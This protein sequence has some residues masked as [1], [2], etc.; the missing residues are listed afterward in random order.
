MSND[1]ELRAM[2]SWDTIKD[3]QTPLT[4]GGIV[5]V[6]G[7]LWS[8]NILNLIWIHG[9]NDALASDVELEAKL[10]TVK[11]EYKDL[12]NGLKLDV[13]AFEA[14]MMSRFDADMIARA[15]REISKID[16]S[17][18]YDKTLTEDE[19]MFKRER[20]RELNTL[21]KCIRDKK[22]NCV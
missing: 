4:W 6:I 7:I 12:F 14:S 15:K 20:K 2:S 1:V 19:K 13:E 5:V 16:E 8:T 11:S 22:D 3:K 9:I 10:T 17:I 18:K 21:I